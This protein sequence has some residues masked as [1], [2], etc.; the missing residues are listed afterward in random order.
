VIVLV[1]HQHWRQLV[2]QLQAASEANQLQKAWESRFASIE[3]QQKRNDSRPALV[4]AE[5]F[6][7]ETH[8]IEGRLAQL[9]QKP[10]EQVSADTIRTLDAR[11]TALEAIRTRASRPSA[12]ALALNSQSTPSK[13]VA[14]PP[15]RL[16]GLENRGGEMFLSISPLRAVSLSEMSVLRVGDVQSGWQL[17][18]LDGKAATFRFQGQVHRLAVP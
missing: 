12:P 3:Q 5:R 11:V 15:F 8:A 14:E 13:D 9:E 10:S 1:D 6:A 2:P 16:L 7:N 18:S 17:E 4:S